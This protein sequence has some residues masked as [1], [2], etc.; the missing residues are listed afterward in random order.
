MPK[1]YAIVGLGDRSRTYTNALFSTYR[2]QAQL[3]G[4]CD[5]NHTRMDV[6]NRRATELFHLDPVP[7]YA[8]NDFERMLKEQKVDTV[9]VTSMDRTHH[10]YIVNAMQLGCDAITEKPM[11]ID[12]AKCQAILD[13]QKST[14]QH[15]TVTFNYRYAPHNSQIKS[16]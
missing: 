4:L 3:V 15:L 2:E 14:G 10:H 1:R 7:T 16:I 5:T 8:P 12:A 13:T 9:I 11:T 6:T